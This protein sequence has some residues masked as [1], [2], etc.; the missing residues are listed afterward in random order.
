MTPTF[1]NIDE[2]SFDLTDVIPLRN[3]GEVFG[4][5]MAT[6]CNGAIKINKINAAGN[7]TTTYSY[8]YT[9][10]KIGW[11]AGDDAVEKGAVQFSSGEAMLVNNG[12]KGVS[13]LFRVAGAV[14]LI[15]K[16]LVPAGYS[17]FGNSTPTSIDLTNVEMLNNEGEVFGT[18]MATRCNGA[19]KINKISD[20]GNYTTTYSY[21]YTSGKQGW[22]AGDDAVTAGSVTFEPGEAF[23]INNGYKGVSVMMKLPSPISE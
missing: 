21:F 20:A 2:T 7:Y 23:L 14:D 4:T 10:S 18:S 16:N 13:V 5:A 19:I 6:R 3:D 8:F 12:Y 15:N 9:S 17:L 1:K 22:Y 11:Y